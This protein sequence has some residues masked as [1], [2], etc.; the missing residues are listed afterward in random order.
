MVHWVGP[1]KSSPA[2]V[3]EASKA[4]EIYKKIHQTLTKIP[5]YASP[6]QDFTPVCSEPGAAPPQQ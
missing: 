4:K 6:E 2:K 5:F 1:T 3:F